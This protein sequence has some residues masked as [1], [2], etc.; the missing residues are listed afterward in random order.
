MDILSSGSFVPLDNKERMEQ[1]A[2][3]AKTL[4]TEVSRADG[5]QSSG[6]SNYQLGL[7]MWK[8]AEYVCRAHEE[9]NIRNIFLSK[10]LE[11]LREIEK[12]NAMRPRSPQAQVFDSPTTR[13]F[14]PVH[15]Q[16]ATATLSIP[17]GPASLS[18]PSHSPDRALQQEQEEPADEYLGVV[19]D[20]N[21][22]E[23]KRP[24]YSDECIPEFD[25]A[26]EAIVDRLEAEDPE[27]VGTGSEQTEIVTSAGASPGKAEP[28][29]PP[30]AAPDVPSQVLE[31]DIRTELLGSPEPCPVESIVLA[32]KE[33][34]NFDSCTVTAV[35]QLLPEADGARRCVVSVRTHD[36][37]PT[38]A[39]VDVSAADALSRI[40]GA[41][42]LLFER[43]R[44]ELPARAAEKLK[45]EKPA[46]KKAAKPAAKAGKPAAAGAK[47]DA[48]PTASTGA[49]GA[50]Q[51]QQGLFA[52]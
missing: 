23:T 24:S 48:A 49:V 10:F 41:L 32:E 46:A 21:E 38:V 11:T 36:F 4:A 20:D 34:Y 14:D 44:N 29:E 26:I 17:S 47:S 9:A 3:T 6:P 27:S 30:P 31:K 15:P 13:P 22:I 12:Q 50:E 25:A 45:K 52:T 2:F 33:P 43:Y 39:I 5:F 35:V 19:P 28:N 51:N 16:G 8:G 18:E 42:G 40:S 1:L 7:E 37:T